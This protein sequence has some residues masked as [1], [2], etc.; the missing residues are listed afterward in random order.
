MSD[1]AQK[2]AK[3]SWTWG[4]FN[5]NTCLNC[6][7]YVMLKSASCYFVCGSQLL[8]NPF[9][10][11]YTSKYCNK[12]SYSHVC[13]YKGAKPHINKTKMFTSNYLFMYSH[14]QYVKEALIKPNMSIKGIF[15]STHYS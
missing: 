9:A 10:F 6:Y 8:P 11:T 13:V 7:Y 4:T 1:K 15:N 5:T 14:K 3:V 12:K 2:Q